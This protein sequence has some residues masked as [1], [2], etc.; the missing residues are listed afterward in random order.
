MYHQ[1]RQFNQLQNS[2]MTHDS[3]NYLNNLNDDH[4]Q[5]VTRTSTVTTTGSTMRSY[6]AQSDYSDTTRC[7]K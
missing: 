7:L 2:T 4:H 3:L 6:Y 1:Q 5:M